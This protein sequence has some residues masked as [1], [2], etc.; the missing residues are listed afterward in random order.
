M[1]RPL[2]ALVALALALPAA[3]NPKLLVYVAEADV[4]GL[5]ITSSGIGTSVCA[6]LERRPDLE[7]ICAPDVRQ[8]IEAAA[9]MAA[10]GGA[11]NSLA[12]LEARVAKADFVAHP[13][14]R[15]DGNKLKLLLRLYKS[16][17][18][19]GGIAYAG[20]PAGRVVA[21]ADDM[22]LESL[23]TS[24]D[25]AAARADKMLHEPRNDPRAPP[26]PPAALE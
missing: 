26:A 7:V 1:S 17:E 12:A 15:K 20:E 11:S 13:F 24:L 4:K 14:V 25:A 6:A 9:Q 3:A 8:M 18:A 2:V 23:L 21:L 22:K 10:L 19:V 16:R 5:D